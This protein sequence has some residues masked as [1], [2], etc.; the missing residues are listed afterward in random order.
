MKETTIHRR[1]KCG[2]GRARFSA[3]SWIAC[4]LIGGVGGTGLARRQCGGRYYSV[5]YYLDNSPTTLT[6]SGTGSATYN[7][8]NLPLVMTSA[9]TVNLGGSVYNLSGEGLY[10]IYDN[11]T[12]VRQAFVY[13][14]DPWPFAG[15]SPGFTYMRGGMTLIQWPSWTPSSKTARRSR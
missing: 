7:V 3:F 4:C 11:S 13:A 14:G 10:Q 2:S 1:W 12:L 8:D 6:A 9:A 5:E 15:S